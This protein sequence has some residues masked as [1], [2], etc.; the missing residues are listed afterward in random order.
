MKGV[1]M[2]KTHVLVELKQYAIYA[3][4]YLDK[5]LELH[6][7]KPYRKWSF[8]KYIYKQ[9]TFEKIL[10]RIKTKQ[11]QGDNKQV[12]VGFGNWSNPHNSIILGHHRGPVQEVKNKLQVLC[13]VVVVDKFCTSKLCCHFHCEMTQVKYHG[14][15][16]NSVLHCS[17]N[18]C[19]ITID[20]D[21][22]GARN[23]Y[24]FLEKMI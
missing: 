9:K 12:I 17:N 7:N 19:G 13:K 15:E 20:C 4:R 18:E 1:M 22:N 2:P 14:K 16:I 10:Q 24:M 8:K 3:S 23:I 11:S 21:I 5:T 6:L